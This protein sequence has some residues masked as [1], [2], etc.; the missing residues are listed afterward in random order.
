MPGCFDS[1]TLVAFQIRMSGL[2]YI[3]AE[4][5]ESSYG[6]SVRYASGLQNFGLIFSSRNREVDGTLEG[7]IAAAQKWQAQAPS[8]RY[9]SRRVEE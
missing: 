7:A 6:Y 2:G 9:V 4:I 1:Q 8:H 5:V 3:E